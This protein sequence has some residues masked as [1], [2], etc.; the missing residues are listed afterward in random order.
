[1]ETEINTCSASSVMAFQVL[2]P[3]TWSVC[4]RL[5][6]DCVLA[7]RGERVVLRNV[8]CGRPVAQRDSYTRADR[9]KE[10][11]VRRCATR[12]RQALIAMPNT[13]KA[14]AIKVMRTS[15]VRSRKRNSCDGGVGLMRWSTDTSSGSGSCSLLSIWSAVR[16]FGRS[17]YASDSR[18]VDVRVD[19]AHRRWMA[20]R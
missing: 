16:S 12:R 19:T 15:T 3:P 6:C 7:S 14:K 1:M 10:R 18:P 8:A 4:S 11:G 13:A 2:F 20:F 5:P 17:R 9:A